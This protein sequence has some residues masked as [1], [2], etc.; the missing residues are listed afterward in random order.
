MPILSA[1]LVHGCDLCPI[2]KGSDFNAEQVDRIKRMPG[3]W[4]QSVSQRSREW[5]EY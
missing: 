4:V 2:A 1:C 3:A 5:F